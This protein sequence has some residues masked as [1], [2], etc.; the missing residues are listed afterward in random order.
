MAEPPPSFTPASGAPTAAGQPQPPL[1][2][3]LGGRPPYFM[4]NGVPHVKAI[5]MRLLEV[6]QANATV[7]VPFS[8]RFIG[9][10][11]TGVIH[12]GVV[13]T[14]LDNVSGIAVFC[15]LEKPSATATLDL[16][17]DYMR[18]A[19]PGEPI[20]AHAHCYKVS[21]TIAF[22]RGTAYNGDYNDPI[23]TSTAA[24]ML[25]SLGKSS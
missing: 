14:I 4:L 9:N 16:R 13:T 18:P 10:R 24:F 25:T 5:G 17:I 12:G 19:T 1:L 8:D 7:M 2:E 20:Q 23:A 21:R 3:A 6:W 22:V 15:A 11:E